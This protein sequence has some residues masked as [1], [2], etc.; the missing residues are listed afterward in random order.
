M[1][2]FRGGALVYINSGKSFGPAAFAALYWLTTSYGL[3]FASVAAPA[4]LAVHCLA[5]HATGF[6][7]TCLEEGLDSRLSMPLAAPIPIGRYDLL[8]V[9]FMQVPP[10]RN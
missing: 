4:L 7:C 9:N 2:A 6:R 3:A 5:R 8:D 1:V 10:P